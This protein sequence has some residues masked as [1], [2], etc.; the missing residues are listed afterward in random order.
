MKYLYFALLFLTI[1]ACKR[2]DNINQLGDYKP[3]DKPGTC[4]VMS[5]T[6][7]NGS[8]IGYVY[9]DNKVENLTGFSDFD[10]F[11]YEGSKIIE[12]KNSNNNS[13]GIKFNYNGNNQVSEIIFEGRDSQNRPFLHKSF[14]IYNNKNQIE[15][16][17]LDLP[18]FEDRLTTFLEY[19]NKGN[20]TKISAVQYDQLNTLLE[21]LNFDDKKSPFNDSGIGPFLTYFMVYT[22]V[23]GGENMSYLINVNNPI[24]SIV[25][26]NNTK[27]EYGYDY[28]YNPNGY[29]VK[30]NITQKTNNRLKSLTEYFEY[31]C[32]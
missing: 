12:A 30:S 4:K 31:Q 5:N 11:I 17:V 25:Y 6:R 13:Y 20:V 7:Q 2:Q 32:L 14:V 3:S 23:Q 9:N 1:L 24:S 19:D 27:I 29:P 15:E 26:S 28:E 18:V 22:L 8:R 21:N 16:L 10:T